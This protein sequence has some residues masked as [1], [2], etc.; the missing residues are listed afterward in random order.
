[1][2]SKSI[3]KTAKTT[4]FCV[5]ITSMLIISVIMLYPL[6]FMILAGLFTKEEYWARQSSMGLFPIA[7]YPTLENFLA[8]FGG[9]NYDYSTVNLTRSAINSVTIT[10]VGTVATV[11]TTMLSGYAFS[12]LRWKGREVFLFFLLATSML[13]GTVS[14]IPR[15]MMYSKVFGGILDTYW[16]YFIGVPSLNVMGTFIVTQYMHSIPI[17]IDESAKLDGAHTLQIMFKI[18]FPIAKPVFGYI[19]ITTAIGIWNDWSTGFFFTSDQALLTLPAAISRISKSGNSGTP[20]YPF[21][22]AAGLSLTLP[23]MVVYFIFQKYLVAGIASAAIK[24]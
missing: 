24:G 13:P 17:S 23:L 3:K 19:I 2:N 22:I 15:Y 12:R 18:L 1:M 21:L 20:D 14:L 4:F 8:V 9:V 5:K 7:E 16:V 11:I 10:T 6:I